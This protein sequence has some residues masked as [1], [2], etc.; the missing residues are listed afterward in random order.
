V[1]LSNTWLLS[2]NGHLP[3]R[4]SSDACM[5]K[6]AKKFVGPSANDAGNGDSEE[7]GAPRSK[8]WNSRRERNGCAA[9]P[10]KKRENRENP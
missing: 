2:S 4:K 8:S 7:S 5:Q 6:C 9:M 3:I 10:R 1:I